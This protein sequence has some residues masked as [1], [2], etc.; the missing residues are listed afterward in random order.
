MEVVN[1]MLMSVLL[2]GQQLNRLQITAA[3]LIVIAQMI[4]QDIGSP[5]PKFSRKRQYD[6]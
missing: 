6:C 3:L 1:A 2:L 4:R 5:V